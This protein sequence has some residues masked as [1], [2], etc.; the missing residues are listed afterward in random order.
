MQL[1]LIRSNDRSG[2][3]L[4][5]RPQSSLGMRLGGSE[6]SFVLEHFLIVNA[7]FMHWYTTCSCYCTLAQWTIL[8]CIQWYNSA[9]TFSK[10]T[11]DNSLLWS[12]LFCVCLLC[13]EDWSELD[14]IEPIK[15]RILFFSLSE[16]CVS[17]IC[18]LLTSKS[19]TLQEKGV[20]LSN[21]MQNA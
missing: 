7:K 9:D 4:V 13:L 2:G 8:L 19:F 15:T 12:I 1:A 3:T 18:S 5:S 17:Y 11:E 20:V 6:P 16:L 14:V 21:Y 10:K